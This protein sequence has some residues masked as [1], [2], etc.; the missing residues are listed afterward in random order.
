MT[1]SAKL[2]TRGYKPDFEFFLQ[3]KHMEQEPQILDDDLP[4]AFNDWIVNQDI[5]D[6]IYWANEY[7]KTFREEAAV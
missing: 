6:I 4:D 5:D 3:M 7:A 2:A 1:E